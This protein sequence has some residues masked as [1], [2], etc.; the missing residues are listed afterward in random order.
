MARKGLRQDLRSA[1]H[2]AVR[3]KK[4]VVL[5]RIAVKSNG[6][7]QR[8]NLTVRPLA[9]LGEEANLFLVVFQDLTESRRKDRATKPSSASEVSAVQQLEDELRSMREHLQTTVEELETSNEELKSSNEE[10]MSMNEE[11][12]SANEELQTS[13]EEL[14]SVNEELE[15][16]NAELGAKVEELD[17]VNS[18]LQNLL[19]SS[20]IATVF[21]SHDLRINRF[22][23]AATDIF[24]LIESDVGRPITD[25]TARI[26]DQGLEAEFR[27]VLRTL[28]PR[29][30]QVRLLDREGCYLMRVSPYRTL[31]HVI[32]GVVV[33]FVDVTEMERSRAQ[34]AQVAAVVNSTS[35]A[36]FT[37]TLE[38][39]ITSWNSG[40]ERMYGWSPAEV[41]GRNVA[42]L[43]P[44][45]LNGQPEEIVARLRRGEE[46]LG[47]ETTR[48]RKD[49]TRLDVS[50]TC[51]VV[52][53]QSGEFIS[54]IARDIS[55]NKR[56]EREL[57]RANDALQHTNEDLQQLAYATSHDLQEPLRMISNYAQLLSRQVG[58]TLDE[59]SR[60]FLVNVLNGATRLGALL[61]A[62]QEYW[63][64]DHRG[65]ELM[66]VD[67]NPVLDQAI[68]NLKMAIDESGAEITRDPL[69]ILFLHETPLLQLLQNLLENA[70][71]YR[72]EGV[73]PR[74]HVGARRAEGMWEISIADNGVGVPEKHLDHIFH[75]FRRLH[76]EQFPGVGMGLAICARIVAFFGGRIWVEPNADGA[77]F[78]FSFPI[79]QVK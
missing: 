14:Q 47:M 68:R 45:E 1:L 26:A 34:A 41:I 6:G 48:V 4:Q 63:S 71:K 11:L 21:L 72:K 59:K 8:I 57:K 19:Q 79:E 27:Q 60:S 36:V 78:K 69:P 77:T 20:H 37:K 49:G 62:L 30:R 55:E 61:R 18:D 38:C 7:I 13:K 73:P 10:L 58:E 16:V 22:T 28:V 12:Q 44:P 67:A 2:Q 74:I 52:R 53:D 65:L 5:E 17:T 15:T 46:V 51:S 25:I 66:T 33:T 3:N 54:V 9:E 75:P 43:V 23:V 24:R 76:G 32:E 31:N 42:I 64:I 39:Q 40:A 35:D 70:L 29:E 50:L 56:A